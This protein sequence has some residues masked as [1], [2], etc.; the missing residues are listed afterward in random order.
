MTPMNRTNIVAFDHRLKTAEVDAICSRAGVTREQ[1][2]QTGRIDLG[3]G[4]KL[5]MYHHGSR[6][7]YLYSDQNRRDG[8]LDIQ[9]MP[10][11]VRTAAIAQMCDEFGYTRAQLAEILSQNLTADQNQAVMHALAVG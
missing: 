8:L 7:V 2:D 9:H 3:P 11:E 10:E 6:H 5:V 1:L 4:R